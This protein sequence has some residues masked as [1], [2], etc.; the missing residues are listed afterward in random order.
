MKKK[1][2]KMLH[3][4][5]FDFPSSCM[6]FILLCLGGNLQ[7]SGYFSYYVYYISSL[8]GKI[9]KK[10]ELKIWQAHAF[11]LKFK[12]NEDNTLLNNMKLHLCI[13]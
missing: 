10:K 13:F 5:Q 9:R 8:V 6:Y 1:A 2:F 11:Y 7:L 12:K 3:P 4:S